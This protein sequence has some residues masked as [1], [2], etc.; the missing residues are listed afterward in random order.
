MASADE[1]QSWH[2]LFKIH[3]GFLAYSDMAQL[4]KK[5]LGVL[6]EIDEYK[7]IRFKRVK[8]NP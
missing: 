1:S 4:D 8:I 3:N 2:G 6:Y 7:K 5:S